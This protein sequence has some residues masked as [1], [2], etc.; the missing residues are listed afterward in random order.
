MIYPVAAHGKRWRIEA[1]PESRQAQDFARRQ[2][3]ES[4]LLEH[5]YEQ[6]W[7][8]AAIDVGASI[9]NH[10]IYLDRVCGLHVLAFEPLFFGELLVNLRLSRSWKVEPQ[11]YALGSKKG[12]ARSVHKGAAEGRLELGSGEVEVRRLDSFEIP[13][14]V[15]CVKIDVEGME[16]EVLRGAKK[17]LASQR[18]VV[19]AEAADEGAREAQ[20]EV[21]EPL[22]YQVNPALGPRATSTRVLRWDYAGS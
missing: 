14:G 6:G 11:P 13:G 12:E 16:P 21:L 17:L 2:P 3:Y 18:P 7:R 1:H 22:G 10:S 20:A 19:F 4:G 9:G 5:I 8:G 15:S